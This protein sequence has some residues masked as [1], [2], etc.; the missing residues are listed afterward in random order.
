MTEQ[1]RLGGISATG[2]NRP[3]L[4]SRLGFGFGFGLTDRT[5]R[6]V[7][8]TVSFHSQKLYLKLGVAKQE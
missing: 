6:S 8:E 5:K 1:H 3:K 2:S 4:E 7:A